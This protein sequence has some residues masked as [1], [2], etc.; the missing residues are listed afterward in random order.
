VD[1]RPEVR[2]LV[3]D[4]TAKLAAINKTLTNGNRRGWSPSESGSIATSSTR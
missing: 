3:E 1:G 4:H 2:E